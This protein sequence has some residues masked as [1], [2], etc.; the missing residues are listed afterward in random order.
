MEHT[1][2]RR[3]PPSGAWGPGGTFRQHLGRRGCPGCA[4][5]WT[6]GR[7]SRS[8]PRPAARGLVPPRTRG[9]SR[10]SGSLRGH[11]D[12]QPGFAA[13]AEARLRRRRGSGPRGASGGRPGLGGRRRQAASSAGLPS[14]GPRCLCAK[15]R[16]VLSRGKAL[17]Q[18]SQ[19]TGQRF[20]S[21]PF[22]QGAN[23]MPPTPQVASSSAEQGAHARAP[24][25]PPRRLFRP[26]GDTLTQGAGAAGAGLRLV[27]LG[28]ERPE[29]RWAG[30]RD[31]EHGGPRELGQAGPA[32]DPFPPDPCQ[33]SKIYLCRKTCRSRSGLY[34]VSFP[35][36]AS[37]GQEVPTKAGRHV[38]GG[39]EGAPRPPASPR[40]V[41]RQ[42]P[43]WETRGPGGGAS[44]EIAC[45]PCAP[46]GPWQWGTQVC[47]VC[48]EALGHL[49]L[50]L[51]PQ[52][53]LQRKQAWG[54]LR[55]RARIAGPHGRAGSPVPG[56]P[57]PPVTHPPAPRRAG[58]LS[59]LRP[60]KLLG[61]FP[62]QP[63]RGHRHRV[64][65]VSDMKGLY[66]E[67]TAE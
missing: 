5:P 13:P 21:A 54:G 47:G 19:E 23:H 26:V 8:D 12:T 59:L 35:R 30:V 44:P 2:S 28:L 45:P 58:R 62:A 31:R 41:P 14:L 42:R 9:R 1:S 27:G 6:V 38:R 39:V 34:V 49:T 64:S 50:H 52:N 24:G 3:Q 10:A 55:G 33:E 40:P 7:S 60:E 25:G 46:R 66:G 56:G 57:C 16:A 37:W 63:P 4:A 61:P 32:Q 65:S 15:G 11:R 67:N 18:G 53:P 22:L 20:G 17:L 36:C 29:P 48:A 43:G 51:H